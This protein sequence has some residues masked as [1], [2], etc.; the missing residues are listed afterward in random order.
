M[1]NEE[2]RKAVRES[3]CRIAVQENS[4][5]GLA[6]SCGCGSPEETASRTIGYTLDWI[7]R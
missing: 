1:K 6:N 5:Y 3:Y 7:E 2:I 4:C